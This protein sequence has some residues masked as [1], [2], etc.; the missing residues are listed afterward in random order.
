MISKQISILSI[1][2]GTMMQLKM[3]ATDNVGYHYNILLFPL[4]RAM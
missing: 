4:R 1:I 2:S 3:S